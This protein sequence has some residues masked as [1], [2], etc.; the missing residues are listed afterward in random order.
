MFDYYVQSNTR[1]NVVSKQQSLNGAF[2]NQQLDLRSDRNDVKA[3][4]LLQ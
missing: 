2:T 4:L 3:E 1:N